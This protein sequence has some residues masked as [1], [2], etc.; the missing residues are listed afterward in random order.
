[1]NSF[2]N[3]TSAPQEKVYLHTDKPYYFAGDTIWMKGYQVHAI[4]HFPEYGSRYLYVELVD[5]KDR[6]VR[7]LKLEKEDHSYLG[8]LPVPKDIEEGDYYLRAYTRW[9]C[10]A[11][12]EYFFSRNLRIIASQT[13]FMISEI[14]YEQTDERRMAI[15]TFRK[16]DGQPYVGHYV[17]YMVRTDE[18]GN[19]FREQKTNQQGEIR[20]EIP[21]KRSLP[22]YI[23]VVLEDRILQHK[24]TFYVPDV[25]DYEV[26]FF[27]EG[28]YLIA[29]NTQKVGFKAIDTEGHSVEIDG[30]VLDQ[31]GDTLTHF[32]SQHAGIGSFLLSTSSGDKYRAVVTTPQGLT[33]EFDLP[34]PER[35]KCAL[36][37]TVRND[38]LRYRVLQG[39]SQAGSKPYYLVAHIRGL[40]LFVKSLDGPE[41][42][43]SLA[44][45]PEGIVTLMLLDQNYL[46]HS[47]RLI[48][49]RDNVTTWNIHPDQT[50]Y[51]PR[52]LVTLDISLKDR[53]GHPFSGD[54]SLSVT[55][56]R[57]VAI[58][59]VGDNI[60]S[61][62]LLTS[63]LKGYVESPGYY[64]RD[65]SSRTL[66]CLDNLMLTQGWSRFDIQELMS[67]KQEQPKF[68]ME[69]Q[70][71]ISG[72]VSNSGKP[73]TNKGISISVGQK[74][75]SYLQT[76]AQ[77]RFVVPGN[78]D[79]D[80]EM[81]TVRLL[82]ETGFVR[83]K[84][85]IDKDQFPEMLNKTPYQSG[86]YQPEQAQYIESLQSPYVM[87]DGIW[88]V[89]LPEVVIDTKYL[90]RERFSSY[91]MNDE[92]EMAQ[93]KT[94]TA[95]QL[96]KEMPG[97]QI[98]DNLLYINPDRSMVPKTSIRDDGRNKLAVRPKTISTGPQ[99]RMYGMNAT[100]HLDDKGI[101]LSELAKI[102]ASEIQ[103][104]YKMDPEVYDALLGIKV[105]DLEEEYISMLESQGSIEE[106][107]KKLF[108]ED[109]LKRLTDNPRPLSGGYISLV[110]KSGTYVRSSL[111]SRI[112]H[113][114]LKSVDTYK[115]HYSPRYD[116]SK[117]RLSPVSDNRTTVHWQPRLALNE[118]G[119]ASIQFY[120]TDHPGAYTVRVEGITHE[121]IP[122]SY[123]CVFEQ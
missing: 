57:S 61:H 109:F 53:E 108:E 44:G 90:I 40:V 25:F 20:L 79:S 11:D 99:F 56:N 49:L 78:H 31:L 6:L 41:G 8:Y 7:R 80:N 58:D 50:T 48:F 106:W 113:T 21:E 19:A 24:H 77:G 52:S 88:M 15:I 66:A 71:V 116:T 120:T 34:L 65:E 122:C 2:E 10:N 114:Y 117:Q 75:S 38:V 86:R 119:E 18:A 98:I 73:E 39:S 42:A 9:M 97:V 35:D 67:K 28:G 110:S 36:S 30:Y 1:M 89:R 76:D 87:E 45:L 111:D 69:M 72:Y 47:E 96:V 16:T 121:G 62:L 54:F 51:D 115:E 4:S 112:D 95:L 104:V 107:E 23:Y 74:L 3:I 83:P 22:Q 59:S 13:A 37:A 12:Q 68:L 46:P 103:A 102:D 32:S 101:S 17:R 55:E 63:D 27:P 105:K 26:D 70:H 100:L 93:K 14:R 81:I 5:R 60:L 123:H 29:D 85:E 33:K 43:V 84:L 92:E 64:F 91:K 94:K 118:Q 82:G